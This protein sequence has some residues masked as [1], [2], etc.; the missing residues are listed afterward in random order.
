MI[1][2]KFVLKH[3][4]GC[5]QQ[6]ITEG[7]DYTFYFYRFLF[8]LTDPGISGLEPFPGFNAVSNFAINPP[9]L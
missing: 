8:F 1:T 2:T 3:E 4:T 9:L 7:R 6:N 5:P